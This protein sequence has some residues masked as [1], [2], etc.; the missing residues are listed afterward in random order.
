MEKYVSVKG[1][2]QEPLQKQKNTRKQSVR[3]LVPQKQNWTL[4]EEHL[5]S[6][7]KGELICPWHHFMTSNRPE[8]QCAF[9][10]DSN[11]GDYFSSV[12]PWYVVGCL[13]EDTF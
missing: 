9:L 10:N 11:G 2:N 4:T 8:Y 7:K 12:L 3:E 13:G 6:P 5:L 1:W